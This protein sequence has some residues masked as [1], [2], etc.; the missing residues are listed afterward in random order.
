[1]L[2]IGADAPQFNYL[3]QN[4]NNPVLIHFFPKAG[5]STCNMELS[6]INDLT[7]M[8]PNSDMK[9]VAISCDTQSSLDALKSSQEFQFDFVS[10]EDRSIST[11]YESLNQAFDVSDRTSYL[12]INNKITWSVNNQNGR[13]IMPEYGRLFKGYRP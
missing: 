8:F 10:D 4:S 5:T 11:A 13:S 1:M 9:V 7:K 6:K 2:A 3:T 12:V